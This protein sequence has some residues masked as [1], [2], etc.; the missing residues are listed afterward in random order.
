[1]K[2]F[3]VLVRW[4]MEHGMSVAVTISYDEPRTWYVQFADFEI[5]DGRILGCARGSGS[6]L[7]EAARSYLEAINGKRLVRDPMDPIR[8]HEVE[9]P[10][11]VML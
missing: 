11:V 7:D 6:T 3:E 10:C 5:L 2:A 1:M 4:G 8:R 9:G